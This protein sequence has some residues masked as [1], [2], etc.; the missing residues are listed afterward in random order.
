MLKPSLIANINLFERLSEFKNNNHIVNRICTIQLRIASE[1]KRRRKDV[2]QF[3]SSSE[4]AKCMLSH[5]S[6]IV[7]KQ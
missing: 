4:T 2:E 3:V 5:C 1:Y 6:T 7:D